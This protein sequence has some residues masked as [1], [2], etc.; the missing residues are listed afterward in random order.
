MVSPY[1]WDFPGGVKRHV[2]GLARALRSRGHRV[3]VMAPARRGGENFISAGRSVPI[4]FNRSV[5]RLGLGPGTLKAVFSALRMDFDIVH[6]HEPLV[7]GPCLLS[8]VSNSLPLV[9]T[10]HAAREEGSWAYALGRPCL[11]KLIGR[12]SAR[13][14]VS[15]AAE[16][17]VS[18]YFP[19]DYRIIPNGVDIETFSPHGTDL[20]ESL[21]LDRQG[22]V[23]LFVGRN[24]PRKGLAIAL[25]AFKRFRSSGR[26][27]WMLVV[28]TDDVPE[29][30]DGVLPMGVVGEEEL[31]SVYRTADLL[32]APSLGGESFGMIL[33]E[34][35]ACGVPVI[36][37]DIPGYR[38]VL[39][40]GI[41]GRLVPPG[42]VDALLRSMEELATDPLLRRDM[43]VDALERAK[44]FSWAWV[45]QLVEEVYREAVAGP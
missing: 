27:A 3:I 37:S 22:M 11:S 8:L 17:F 45:S 13:I 10:F 21:G 29:K 20:R 42:D 9:G 33:V 44:Q 15:P 16:S 19:G 34:A 31:P 4:P 12:L 30:E 5:A 43:A 18:R 7:P 36:A 32:L 24:E 38:Y 41:G 26:K 1:S 39:A 35:M 25:K 14:A 6:L 28:G 2:E 23:F 40:D